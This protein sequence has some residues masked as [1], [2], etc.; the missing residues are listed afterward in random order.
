MGIDNSHILLFCHSYGMIKKKRINDGDI[1]K[2]Q[3][4]FCTGKSRIGKWIIYFNNFYPLF[5]I[6]IR[7][8]IRRIGYIDIVISIICQPLD[9]AIDRRYS[10]PFSPSPN[11]EWGNMN[12]SLFL[13]HFKYKIQIIFFWHYTLFPTRPSTSGLISEHITM[14][15][16]ECASLCCSSSTSSRGKWKELRYRRVA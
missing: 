12:N 1:K 10:Y 7:T 15:I 6:I 16:R 2:Q 14:R 11:G 3:I 13:H 5:G 9:G 8:C 4:N